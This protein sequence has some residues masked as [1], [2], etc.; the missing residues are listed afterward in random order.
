MPKNIPLQLQM[1]KEQEVTTLCRLVKVIC[2][3][4]DTFGFTSLDRDL[5]YDDLSSSNGELLYHWLPGVEMSRLQSTI[6]TGI[7]NANVDGLVSAL[8][9][10]GI[11][12]M[13]IQAGKLDYAD[14]WIYLIDYT[15][16]DS[17]GGLV[18][19]LHEIISRSK[20]GE[21]STSD[22]FFTGESRSLSQIWKQAITQVTSLT[23]RTQ[24]GSPQC[25]K[26]F[27]WTAGTVTSVDTAEP[28]RVFTA[29][30]LAGAAGFYVPGVVYWLT[31]NNAG[32]Y[33]E[34]E[35]FRVAVAGKVELLLPLGFNIQV[36]DTFEIRQD[37]SKVWD[38][39]AHGCLYHWAADRPLH[40]RGEPL[41][42]IG[43]EGELSTPGAEL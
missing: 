26:S 34:V 16:L 41:I 5:L 24:F 43:R 17:N 33:I 27:T 31:G 11:T 21:V 42:P 1:T 2:K 37:C 6:G 13:D 7:D 9:V 36:G 15:L 22:D 28:S 19:G 3:D 23:C 20:W 18:P 25:G 30:A 40:F 8:S 29:S 35:E 39:A 14:L 38:D 10:V 12:E 32:K 4:G